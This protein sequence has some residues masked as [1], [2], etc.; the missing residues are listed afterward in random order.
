MYI[1]KA[2][3]EATHLLSP[4]SSTPRLDA[5]LLLCFVLKQ[6]QLWLRTHETDV[7]GPKQ[8]ANFNRLLK[9]RALN[10]PVAYIVGVREFYGRS[11]DVNKHV[12]VP[13]PESESFM[14]LLTLL[15]NQHEADIKKRELAIARGGASDSY[16]RSAGFLH[17]VIDIGT[18]SGCLAITIKKEL[19]D[20]YVTATDISTPAL[21]VAINNAKQHSA[22]VVFKKQSLLSGDKQGYDIVV[23]N[24]PYVPKD[25]QHPSITQEPHLALYS[26]SDG[27]D[28]YKALFTQL[29]HK[30]I[31][32][33]LTE[34]LLAQHDP[35]C[36]LA[37]DAGYKIVTANGLVQ[38]FKKQ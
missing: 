32:Y 8:Q 22:D 12:L 24:L 36:Q 26:G 4:A 35:V 38:L 3:H 23:A 6:E 17:T 2:L 31:R 5:E 37:N 15:H 11:F 13:R 20:M 9:R 18:G 7:L 1:A 14:T 29:A 34:S 25:M 28:H 10:E 27:L 19:P 16:Q 21:R 33:V 30:H